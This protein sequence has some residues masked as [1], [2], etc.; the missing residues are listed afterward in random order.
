M[1]SSPFS[2]AFNLNSFKKEERDRA[3]IV[4]G[5][6]QKRKLFPPL[7]SRKYDCIAARSIEKARNRSTEYAAIIIAAGIIQV[8]RALNRAGFGGRLFGK[9]GQFEIA[10][11]G[12]RISARTSLVQHQISRIQNRARKTQRETVKVKKAV[13]KGTTF[14]LGI[15]LASRY[16]SDEIL[17]DLINLKGHKDF[18]ESNC[19]PAS[20]GL[21]GIDERGR[22]WGFKPAGNRVNA[23]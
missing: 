12:N 20:G 3:L 1:H 16:S 22:V 2:S 7:L 8:W 13:G 14:A 15:G 11:S 4:E 23:D 18:A 10:P 17:V 19:V 21:F 5:E 6:E 9:I